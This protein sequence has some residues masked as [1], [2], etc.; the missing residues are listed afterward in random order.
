MGIKG[1][2]DVIDPAGRVCSVADYAAEHYLQH[3]RPL[4]IAV[5]EACWRFT[6]LTPAQVAQIQAGEPAANPVEKVILWRILRLMRL[7]VQLLFVGDG[8]RR[9]WKRD[10]RGGNKV[11]YEMLRLT[12]KLLDH[13]KVPHHEAPGEAEA[14][15][16][17][18]QALGVVD[19]VWSDDGDALMFGCGTLIRQHKENGKPVKD[20]V[21]V[22]RADAI[23]DKHDLNAESLVLFALLA[24]GDYATEG[25][26]S[27][28]HVTAAII[29]KKGLGL[30]RAICH[31]SKDSLLIWRQMLQDELSRSGRS[32]EVPFT[33]PDW[34]AVG[35][36][37]SPV[38]STDDQLQNLRGL[39][40]GWDRP[41]DEAKLRLILRQRFNFTTR[42]Y[43]KHI[44]PIFL[45]RALVRAS[46]EQRAEN[47]KYVIK[48]KR[49]RT[50]KGGPESDGSVSGERKISFLP[51]RAVK[52][53]LSRQPEDEDWG[54]FAA[55]DGTPYDPMQSI[56]CEVLECFLKNGLPEGALDAQDEPS[57]SKK[58]K[59]V[60]H[61]DNIHKDLS[62]AETFKKTSAQSH[63]NALARQTT[64]S[65]V[66]VDQGQ[67]L[68]SKKRG[69]PRT[70]SPLDS[71]ATRP[72]PA[73]KVKKPDA[74]T[75]TTTITTSP[76]WLL[77]PKPV[78][79]RPRA[80]PAFVPT[81]IDLTD[82]LSDVDGITN[83]PLLPVI[84][85]ARPSVPPARA[86]L[87]DAP[88]VSSYPPASSPSE[89]M[90][91]PGDVIPLETLRAL[92]ASSI[93]G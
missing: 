14:E 51:S 16:A 93:W 86:D 49:T 9:P 10:R 50:K 61:R 78:F 5:D 8:P 29:A 15:C 36:Y 87:I 46:P 74:T 84:P 80:V 68:V 55:A 33:F 73:K 85:S 71:S 42:E 62:S 77:P 30:A 32:I 21:K 56:E 17:R 82:D 81:V 34:K 64:T 76:E 28:G 31:I 59:S 3:R 70:D 25:L 38:I 37:R 89:S 2:W 91:V 12:R 53:D 6:N 7:N 83:D 54:K 24:G 19:A 23:L 72:S 41:I 18:L 22:Y 20:M 35:H 88:R 44:A 66:D 47:L 48:L 67:S 69:R 52:I 63:E 26:R 65:I 1:L 57:T 79:K 4:R 40:H 60:A 13:L 43:L 58:R 45:T 27:C 75:A 11:D 90:L 92:R 39:Q